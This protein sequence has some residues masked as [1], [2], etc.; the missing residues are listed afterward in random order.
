MTRS[1]GVSFTGL[2][3][4]V[5]FTGLCLGVPII[6]EHTCVCSSKVDVFGTHGLFQA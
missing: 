2:H 5:S 6:V 3:L 1:T 4:G